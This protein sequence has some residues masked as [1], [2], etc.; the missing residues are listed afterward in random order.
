MAVY[1][2]RVVYEVEAEDAPAAVAIVSDH[3]RE[4]EEWTSMAD[5]VGAW[6]GHPDYG[7]QVQRVSDDGHE[8]TYP[9]YPGMA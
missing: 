6:V 9:I 8:E 4:A 3:I 1:R 7:M 5:V 2:V